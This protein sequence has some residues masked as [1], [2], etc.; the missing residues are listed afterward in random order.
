MHID[1]HVEGERFERLCRFRC[2]WLRRGIGCVAA[3]GQNDWIRLTAGPDSSQPCA[4]LDERSVGTD[5]TMCCLL[6]KK[7]KTPLSLFSICLLLLLFIIFATM[8]L[9]AAFEFMSPFF[10]IVFSHY[11][12]TFLHSSQRTSPLSDHP[13][14]HYSL[15]LFLRFLF[16]WK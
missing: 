4:L 14:F 11:H 2:Q 6:K 15:E 12:H 13:F 10:S 3:H 8:G 5:F 1:R 9:C 7:K 16:N